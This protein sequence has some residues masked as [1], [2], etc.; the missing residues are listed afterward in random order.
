MIISATALADF[1]FCPRLFYIK[2][3]L[4]IFKSSKKL[5]EGILAHRGTE[6][7]KAVLRI[8]GVEIRGRADFVKEDRVIELKLSTPSFWISHVTQ[9]SVYARALGKEKL[10]VTY[11]GLGLKLIGKPVKV[12]RVA[13]E[14]VEACRTGRFPKNLK[15]CSLCYYRDVCRVVE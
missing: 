13:E 7:V 12:E 6:E 3:I 15:H 4:K 5:R 9:A 10:E 2:H 1:A 11:K 14:L 8:K